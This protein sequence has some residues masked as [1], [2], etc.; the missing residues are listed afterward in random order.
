MD[1]SALNEAKRRL[2]KQYAALRKA[3]VPDEKAGFEREIASQFLASVPYR[4][5]KRLLVYAPLDDEPD[6]MPICRKAIADGKEVWFPKT[7]GRGVMRFYR[8]SVPEDLTVG[9]FGIREPKEDGAPYENGCE[10]DVCIV[11]GLVFDRRG[12]RIGYGGG[13]YDRFLAGFPGIAAG[14]LFP[15]SLS[16]GDLPRDKRTDKACDVLYTGKEVVVVGG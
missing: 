14:V 3:L 12:V 4:F 1:R 9:R 6:I 13:Y 16:D 11:P 10:T 15:L 8:V 7:Y 2:R 5:C